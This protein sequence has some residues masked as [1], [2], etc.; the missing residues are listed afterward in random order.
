MSKVLIF[1]GAGCVERGDVENCRIR[2][3]IRNNDGRLI[4][5]EMGGNEFTGKNIPQWAKGFKYT[6]RID[7]LF[8]DDASWDASRN[9]STSLSAIARIN[10]EYNKK[11][12]LNLVNVELNCSFTDIKIE[13]EGI[14]VF[15]T[16]EALCDCSK[17][18]YKPFKEIEV[19]INQL[20]GIKPVYD[21]EKMHLGDYKINYEYVKEIPYLNKWIE[22]RTDKEKEDF[23]N[24]NYIVRL[25]WNNEGIIKAMEVTARQNFCNMGLGAE[26]LEY[27]IKSIIKS[28]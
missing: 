4:Y 28:K 6:G 8:Y 27:I 21:N 10:F 13:N 18:V 20:E 24:F 11:T 2:T 15:D 22:E 1:E 14:R 9:Y 12:I 3:R 25:R 5:L 7:H 19:N 23:K 17:K 26:D 16:K